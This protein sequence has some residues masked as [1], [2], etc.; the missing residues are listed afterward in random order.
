[1]NRLRVRHYVL[2]VATLAIGLAADVHT[3]FIGQMLISAVVWA[4]LF[5]LLRQVD[6]HERKAAFTCLAIATVGE[7]ILS[8]GW[9]LYTYRLDN[10]PHFVPPGHV[11]MLLLGVGLARRMP[12]GMAIAVLGGATLYAGAATIGGFDTFASVLVVLLL[13][14]TFAFPQHRRL[15]ASTFLLS[16]V[17]ELYGTWLGN[18]TW[19]E[20]VPK[21]RLMT[22]NPPAL[23]G[24]FYA[25]LDACVFGTMLLLA[26]RAHRAPATAGALQTAGQ[27]L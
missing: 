27:S 9:G 14:V 10:I 1:M 25:T 15:Y 2:M 13:A 22:T 21:L 17:L 11:L 6:P 23:A 18:W 5:H 4:V 24:V 16:L 20:A 8:L 19:M 7:I 12:D 26:R 3:G